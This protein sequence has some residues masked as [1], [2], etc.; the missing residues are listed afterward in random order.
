MPNMKKVLKLILAAAFHRELPMKFFY[1]LQYSLW[2]KVA[3]TARVNGSFGRFYNSAL[4]G[5]RIELPGGKPKY[6][7]AEYTF[8]Q[9]N[10][11]RTKSFFFIDD[12]PS[13]LYENNTYFRLDMG[14][15]I[16]YKGKIETGFT[17]GT[18]PG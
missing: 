2:R 6:L 14:F 8:N 11:Y 17:V 12:T 4:I 1:N 7:E 18:E 5:G 13:F 9:F 3:T 15:P 10:Y 16:T